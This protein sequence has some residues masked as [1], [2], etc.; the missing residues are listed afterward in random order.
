[1]VKTN[2]KISHHMREVE[3]GEREGNLLLLWLP[4]ISPVACF[5]ENKSRKQ[6]GRF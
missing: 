6:V 2:K 4:L 5:L 1:M 3:I